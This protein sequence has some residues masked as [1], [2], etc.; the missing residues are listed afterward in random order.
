MEGTGVRLFTF[1][2]HHAENEDRENEESLRNTKELG[3]GR[4]NLW[5]KFTEI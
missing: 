5:R 3:C 1:H 2:N 4:E